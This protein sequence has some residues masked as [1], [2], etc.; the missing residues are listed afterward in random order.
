MNAERKT[1]HAVI[2]GR[3]QG[4][5]YRAWTKGR[6]DRLGVG[7]WVRNREDRSV[8]AVFSGPAGAVEALLEE[9]RRGPLAARVDGIAVEA[10]EP[11][12]GS[13]FEIRA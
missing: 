10:A 7:G 12:E 2:R 6:A 9:C 3:V 13:G 4:V 5:A 11:F 1:V 8:E